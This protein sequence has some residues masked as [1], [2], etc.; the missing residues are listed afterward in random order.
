M[1]DIYPVLGISLCAF[2]AALGMKSTNIKK[3]VYY[4]IVYFTLLNLF[5]TMQAKYNILHY[6]SMTARN[7][8]EIFGTITRKADSENFLQHP[9]YD[10]AKRGENED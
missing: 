7:Y 10:K 2:F 8:F 5:Q 9:D 1:I 3:A 6:D 4:L